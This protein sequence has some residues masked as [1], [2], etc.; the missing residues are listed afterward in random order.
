MRRRAGRSEKES[1]GS[2][3]H[4]SAGLEHLLLYT[5]GI[6]PGASGRLELSAENGKQVVGQEGEKE[7]GLVFGEGGKGET[8]AHGLVEFAPSVLAGAAKSVLS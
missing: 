5:G 4:A 7:K 6:P 3:H 2:F 8:D 1:S